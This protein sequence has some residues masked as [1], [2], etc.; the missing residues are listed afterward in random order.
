M[1]SPQVSNVNAE[2]PQGAPPPFLTGVPMVNPG[3][4]ADP[5]DAAAVSPAYPPQ[6]QG[7]QQ[8]ISPQQPIS[9]AQSVVSNMAAYSSSEYVRL[10]LVRSLNARRE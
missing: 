5:P 10:V 2:Y 3:G 8:I 7:G 4:Y 1:S 6:Q 9:Q